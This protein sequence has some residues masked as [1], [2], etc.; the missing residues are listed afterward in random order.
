MVVAGTKQRGMALQEQHDG[1]NTSMPET[2]PR[3]EAGHKHLG[4]SLPPSL[5]PLNRDQT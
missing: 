1:E 3:P 2:L 5:Q 4:F